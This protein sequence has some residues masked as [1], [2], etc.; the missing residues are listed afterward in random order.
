MY[1]YVYVQLHIYGYVILYVRFIEH[2]VNLNLLKPL[3][4]PSQ[5]QWHDYF[6]TSC[7]T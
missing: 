6:A 1:M 7:S 5:Y 4:A 2:V 3:N